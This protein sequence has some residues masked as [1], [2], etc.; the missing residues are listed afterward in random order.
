MNHLEKLLA[1]NARFISQKTE[2]VNST[3][4]RAQLAT[5]QSPFAA[6]LCCADSRIAPEIVFDQPLGELF[7]CRVAGN[8]PT[9]EIIES[10]EY[11]V[12]HLG[13]QLIVVAGHASCGAV[14]A[15]FESDHPQGLFSQIA[16]SPTPN[17]DESIAHNA[18]QGAK[19]ILDQSPLILE[20]VESG[21]ATVVSGVQDIA[22]GTFTVLDRYQK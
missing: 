9:P 1:G 5:G 10:L 13:V 16:L 17:L 4:L 6:I 7:V 15:A 3:K 8:V 21:N 2:A 12:G 20:A 14:T 19:T 11:A 18:T 22:S